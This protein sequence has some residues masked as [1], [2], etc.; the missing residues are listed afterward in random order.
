LNLYYS[1]VEKQAPRHLFS[2]QANTHASSFN[3]YPWV[4]RSI[5][6]RF[7][8]WYTYHLAILPA[9]HPVVFTLCD[10]ID[11]R[12]QKQPQLTAP[13]VKEF[14]VGYAQNCDSRFRT[15]TGTNFI[16]QVLTNATVSTLT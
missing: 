7:R 6:D 1:V 16:C 3:E 12:P 9:H 5:G 13:A 10:Q 8:N 15:A 11:C 14:P 4:N 2:L